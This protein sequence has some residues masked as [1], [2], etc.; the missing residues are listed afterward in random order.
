MMM[1]HASK[2]D[3]H[4]DLEAQTSRA[5]CVELLE[6]QNLASRMLRSCALGVVTFDPLSNSAEQ[7]GDHAT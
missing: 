4:K 7:L 2:A 5:A 1:V 6:K 3:I